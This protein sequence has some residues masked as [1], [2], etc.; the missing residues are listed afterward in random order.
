[1]FAFDVDQSAIER[2][3]KLMSAN[4]S[5]VEAARVS[6]LRKFGDRFETRIKREAAKELRIPQK[7]LEG[8]FF[9]NQVAQGDDEL[10]LWIGTWHLSPF[11]IGSP[12]QTGSGVRIGRRSYPGAFLAQIYSGTTKV[13]IRLHSKHYSPELY[14][15]KQRPGDRGLAELRGRFP[16]VRAAVPV[17]EVIAKV[18]AK[19]GEALAGEFVKIFGQ[20]LN[21]QVTV[22]GAR[23]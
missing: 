8:R 7:S 10:R 20:E 3:I 4:E 14:P 21:Y 17:D 11:A 2:A 16:V 5:Q 19:E 22:K 12:Q 9:S 15:T 18:L 23:A 6:A 13:W 1:M